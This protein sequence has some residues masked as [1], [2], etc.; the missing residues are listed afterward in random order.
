MPD[1]P[2]GHTEV[3]PEENPF[4]TDEGRKLAEMQSVLREYGIDTMRLEDDF[5]CH[6]FAAMEQY[7]LRMLEHF[8][9]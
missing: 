2:A 1:Y 3:Y 4:A 5:N 9:L 7:R 6:L 8:K